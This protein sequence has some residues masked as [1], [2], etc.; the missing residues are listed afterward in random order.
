MKHHMIRGSK[1][2][3]KMCNE[4]CAAPLKQGVTEAQLDDA[5]NHTTFEDELVPSD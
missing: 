5:S 2:W 1:S 4:S 3:E